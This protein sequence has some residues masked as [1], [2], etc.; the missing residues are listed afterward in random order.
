MIPPMLESHCPILILTLQKP[1]QALALPLR[2]TQH[3]WRKWGRGWMMS[4]TC[5]VAHH[6]AQR[7]PIQHLL[8]RRM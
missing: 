8:M 2:Q 7:C 6:C 3:H 4:W 5:L 1:H